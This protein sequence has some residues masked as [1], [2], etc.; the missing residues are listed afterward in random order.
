M[1]IE[2]IDKEQIRWMLSKHKCND[3][4]V[5]VVILK[6]DQENQLCLYQCTRCKTIWSRIEDK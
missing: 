4:A 2:N 3:C 1:K 5:R 6:E